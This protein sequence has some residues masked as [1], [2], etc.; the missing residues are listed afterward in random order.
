MS[1]Q[2]L[3]DEVKVTFR[4]SP[5]KPSSIPVLSGLN[6]GRSFY[7]HDRGAPA[8]DKRYERADDESFIIHDGPDSFNHVLMGEGVWYLHAGD[9][10]HISLSHRPYWP[11]S[12][13]KP[14]LVP[15]LG[16]GGHLRIA[17][18]SE[19]KTK[20][21][22]EFDSIDTKFSPGSTTW[23]CS[24][25]ELNTT[26]EL[27][28]NPLIK[29]N[30][31]IVTARA[32][33]EENREITLIWEFGR[34]GEKNDSIVLKE[35]YAQLSNPC[36]KYTQIFVGP[37]GGCY[38]L[39]KGALNVSA[40]SDESLFDLEAGNPKALF[41]VK[42]QAGPGK[43]L[44]NRFLC[45]W[46]YSD[47]DKKGIEDAY[48]RLKDKAFA[49]TQWLEGMKKRWFQHWIGRAL[50]PE[51]KFL[52][53]RSHL[54]EA[55][56]ESMS[57]WHKRKRLNIETPDSQFDTVV[58]SAAVDLRYQ[59]EYPA[60]IHG[61]LGWN[62]Y[63]KINVGYYAADDVGYHDEVENSLKFI[64][65][66]QD[67]K[68]RQCYLS[69]AFATIRWAEEVDFYYVE[70]IWYHYRW[71][72]DL[73]FLKTMWPSARR[74]LE[75]GLAVSD[76]DE[77]GIMTAFYEFWNND[78][79]SRGGKCVVQSAMAWTAL[80]GATEIAKRLGDKKSAKRYEVLSKKVGKQVNKYLWNK[81]VGAFCSAE[82]NDD[83]RPHPETQEQ[84]FPVRCGL[85]DS[86]Q[87]Y[88]AVRYLRDNF[89]LKSDPDVT[90]E[91]INDWWPIFW[92]HHYVSNGDASLSVLAACQAGDVDK[93]WPI[94]R[95]IVKG[96]YL[97]KD[98]TLS[99]TQNEAGVGTGL[100]NTTE[101]QFSFLQAVTEGL[102]GVKPYLGDN[103]LVFRPNFPSEWNQAKIATPD[104][105]YTYSKDGKA[106]TYLVKTPVPRKIR[107][108]IPLRSNIKDVRVNGKKAEYSFESGVNSSRVVI[109]S[110]LAKMHS[111]TIKTG[112]SSTVTGKTSL[113]VGKN[114]KA[115]VK[116]AMLRR[117][118][119]PQQRI[120]DIL[121]E[122]CRNDIFE[123]SFVPVQTGKATVFLELESG[124][125]RWLHPMDLEVQKPWKIVER[126]VT[127]FNKNGPAVTSPNINIK[128]ETLTVE[129]RNN[130]DAELVGPVNIEVAGRVF[131]KDVAV[132]AAGSRPIKISLSNVWH[133]L[134]PGRIPVK[135]EIA[136][137]A[138]TADA[139]NWEVGKER[140]LAFS[141][142]L[143]RINLS[144]HYNIDISRLYSSQFK[145]RLDYTG[146]GGG[147]DW[148][149]PMPSKDKLGYVLMHPPVSQLAW[150][151][152][153]ENTYGPQDRTLSTT[154]FDIQW[155]VPSFK[156]DFQ[157][158][159]GIPFMTG[160]NPI[161]KGVK[162]NILALVNTEPY[163]Q[164]PSAAVL[165]FKEPVRLEKIYL[166]A[167]NLTKTVKCYYPGA[168]AVVHYISGGNEIVQLIPPYTM[169][170]M[171][172]PFAPYSYSIPFGRFT[173]NVSS[174][175]PREKIANVAVSDI[176]LDPGRAV[177]RIEL[178]CVTSETILGILGITL[179][180]KGED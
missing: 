1:K 163:E 36:L 89:F 83:I 88:M 178:R 10:P 19:D 144:K 158:S 160:S 78:A 130:T 64:S 140:S 14:D 35:N 136:G 170:C 44:Q 114:A 16:I 157:T 128:T 82:W 73:E 60:F 71:T 13:I 95:T 125:A 20:W 77:D 39:T 28:L 4:H 5:Q 91:L 129:I 2:T 55:L 74:A 151:C 9:K 132:S 104:F 110:S 108:E 142:R 47:Y 26:I 33:S 85:G 180:G 107:M 105:S 156:N 102:F 116:N 63:G 135:V 80:K 148:R 56:K 84:F 131:K 111:F 115:V 166:L 66:A 100:K 162:N 12:Y 76:P 96:A 18:T 167:A 141:S 152:L 119:D 52:Q 6:I 15:G 62:K 43:N 68:G 59:Y 173:G 92:S 11:N 106:I 97:S 23:H 38:Q 109:E 120:K 94:L 118:I 150:N 81:E 147:V 22:G 75:H 159:I 155:E 171:A 98:A 25:V 154:E 137:N 93:Y 51:K 172:Q 17:V 87:K 133:R 127:A 8:A 149:D 175:G 61:I 40:K 176:M 70:Q 42:L 139:V 34:V 3:N 32:S 138:D 126:Y 27:I 122:R 117:V 146:C 67:K 46:G 153:P 7:D 65:G 164:L 45:V 134:S 50:E 124:K 21:L 86:M 123:A 79:H 41:T 72:G 99:G 24:D 103:L 179:L 121:I 90:L 31:F 37:I 48:R 53:I 101:V 174:F 57:F 168:E 145:W 113:I 58:N 143:K 177:T 30:G 54:D 29:S 169:S 112:Q 161:K 69:P 165:E 49:D